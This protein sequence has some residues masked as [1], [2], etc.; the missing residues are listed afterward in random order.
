MKQVYDEIKHVLHTT[1]TH[2]Q[3]KSKGMWRH[4][5]PFTKRKHD[6]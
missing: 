5:K 2:F 4:K 3:L 1:V 6:K